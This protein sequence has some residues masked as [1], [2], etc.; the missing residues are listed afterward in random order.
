M[1][2]PHEIVQALHHHGHLPA[3][4]SP[5]SY[6]RLRFFSFCPCLD[7]AHVVLI[8][9]TLT[10]RTEKVTS[11]E[12]SEGPREC[13]SVKCRRK[14]FSR[15]FQICTSIWMIHEADDRDGKTLHQRR[16]RGPRHAPRVLGW[17][18]AVGV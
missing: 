10:K 18:G 3:L 12:R 2:R 7:L 15:G 5:Q 6:R 13:V 17:G 1:R 8:A 4:R 9:A 16:S 14:A 11:S